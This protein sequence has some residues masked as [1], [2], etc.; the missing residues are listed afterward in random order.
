MRKTAA[1]MLMLYG[2]NGIYFCHREFILRYVKFYTQAKFIAILSFLR[3]AH[4]GACC[5]IYN[6]YFVVY[7]AGLFW[8]ARGFA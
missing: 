3:M 8:P 1:H 5:R 7:G 6:L 2:R 4:L